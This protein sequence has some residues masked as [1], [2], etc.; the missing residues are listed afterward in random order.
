[1][2]LWPGGGIGQQLPG[3]HQAGG[4]DGGAHAMNVPRGV[5]IVHGQSRAGIVELVGDVAMAMHLLPIRGQNAQPLVRV[6]CRGLGLTQH[7]VQTHQRQALLGI[8]AAHV[9]M[10]AGEPHLPDASARLG[11]GRFVPQAGVEGLALVVDGQGLGRPFDAGA[12]LV[13]GK[14]EAIDQ[15]VDGIGHPQHRKAHRAHRVPH[16][17]EA[18]AGAAMAPARRRQIGLQ[19]PAM[20]SGEFLDRRPAPQ[21]AQQAFQPGAVVM[22]VGA[23]GV[24][25][26]LAQRFV[27]VQ[28]L[29][30]EDA[31]AGDQPRQTAHGEGAA[32]EA[33]QVDVIAGFI[34][35]YQRGIQLPHVARQSPAEG[36]AEDLQR[37]EGGGAHAIVVD[38]DLRH[39]RIVLIDH[40]EQ[41]EHI[42]AAILVG[43]VARAIGTDHDV[44]GHDVAPPCYGFPA[45]SLA[46]APGAGVRHFS[47]TRR[48]DLRASRARHRAGCRLPDPTAGT[49]RCAPARR[50]V[51]R[52]GRRRRRR[53]CRPRS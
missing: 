50:A 12:E 34:H 39:V 20:G 6:R 31:D 10:D 16:P 51:P 45:S 21:T 11:L 32:A 2:D 44:L 9:G 24:L 41:L 42:G 29:R 28:A 53:G 43:R 46:E 40:L 5:A 19:I 35:P 14:L 8:A 3:R 25:H 48:A 27:A 37:P 38:G 1:M 47:A 26:A 15:T 49:C 23:V 13:V 7:P 30:V 33:E 36:A 18:D 4:A 17:H 22:P 52:P